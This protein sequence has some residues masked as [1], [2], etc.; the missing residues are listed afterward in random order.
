MTMFPWIQLCVGGLFTLLSLEQYLAF[1]KT[2]TTVE[3][4]VASRFDKIQES[5][6][7]TDT[8][9]RLHADIISGLQDA[10]LGIAEIANNLNVQMSVFL[11]TTEPFR[12][13]RAHFTTG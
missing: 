6:T 4:I 5:S 10:G 7:A 3:K 13:I 9:Q 8:P 11:L 1:G 12:V 2:L